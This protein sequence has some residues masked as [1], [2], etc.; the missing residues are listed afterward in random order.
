MIALFTYVHSIR[1]NAI[2]IFGCTN[3]TNDRDMLVR[4]WNSSIDEAIKLLTSVLSII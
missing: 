3:L 1:E 4:S 2:T